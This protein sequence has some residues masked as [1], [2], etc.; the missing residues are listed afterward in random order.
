M[1]FGQIPV[2]E[3]EGAIVAHTIRSGGLILKKGQIVTREHK[4]A[5]KAAGVAEITAA[6][7]EEDDVGR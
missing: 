2:A 3:A 5:L 7:L 4:E 1:K 6:Q